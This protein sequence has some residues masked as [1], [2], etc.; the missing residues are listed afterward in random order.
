MNF[1]GD[2]YFALILIF[3]TSKQA[4]LKPDGAFIGEISL[5][6][7]VRDI[8]ERLFASKL[9]KSRRS[10]MYNASVGKRGSVRKLFRVARQRGGIVSRDRV[11][12]TGTQSCY[13]V[14]NLP[15]LSEFR[16]EGISCSSYS[17]R[18]Y[19]FQRTELVTGTNSQLSERSSHARGG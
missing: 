3:D 11:M 12:P 4:L 15:E 14:I 5:A 18:R 9:L 19:T 10:G 8:E 17:P 7:E 6:S 13:F 1:S 2:K 16:L